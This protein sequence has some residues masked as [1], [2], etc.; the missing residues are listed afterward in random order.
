M[1][2]L[3]ESS[4]K[5]YAK[6]FWERQRNKAT[7]D[8]Q[9]ALQDIDVGGDP[10]SWL[11]DLYPYKLP[12][13]CNVIVQI[14]M[15]ET[16]SEAERLLLHHR[17]INDEWMVKRGLVPSPKTRRLGK[18]VATALERN[19]FQTG[20]NGTQLKIYKEWRDKKTVSG[21]MNERPLIEMTWPNEFEIVDGWG[22]LGALLA[23][24]RND[25]SFEPFECFAASAS[26]I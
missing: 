4:L 11:V 10:I 8:D 15:I 2:L 13:P 9:P 14:V 6:Q 7:L 3:R 25:C 17:N 12:K 20:E 19:Y 21:L 5:E 23:L 24:V 26:G 16:L 22:R 1:K 18:L